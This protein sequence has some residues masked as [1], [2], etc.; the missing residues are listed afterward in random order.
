MQIV[1]VARARAGERDG[2]PWRRTCIA[3]IL[4]CSWIVWSIVV[5]LRIVS[6]RLDVLDVAL[7]GQLNLLRDVSASSR[8]YVLQ[9]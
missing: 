1:V 4:R 8:G 5:N 7:I 6:F 2:E 3:T 9:M